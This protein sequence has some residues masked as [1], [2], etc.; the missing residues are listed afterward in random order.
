MLWAIF[1]GLSQNFRRPWPEACVTERKERKK[2]D[3]RMDKVGIIR[4]VLFG[5]I[6]MCK[7]RRIF[8][9]L[10]QWSVRDSP[11]LHIDK[12]PRKKTTLYIPIINN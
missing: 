7:R 10:D 11:A 1:L 4:N 8:H 9:N 2:N 6:S 12:I 5:I 3:S